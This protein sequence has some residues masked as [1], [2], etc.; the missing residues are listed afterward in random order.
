M[1][2]MYGVRSVYA[3]LLGQLIAPTYDNG[4]ECEPASCTAAES[5]RL[6]PSHKGDP[7]T[8]RDHSEKKNLNIENLPNAILCIGTRSTV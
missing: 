8:L 4:L 2:C 3:S 5:I 1:V 7:Y 6:P